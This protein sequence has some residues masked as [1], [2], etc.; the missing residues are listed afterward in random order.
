[1]LAARAH[2]GNFVELKNTYMGESAK[3]GH[4][5]YLG[6]SE[7]G[8]RTNIGAGTITC[9]YDGANKSKTIMGEDVFIGSNS[10]LVA[11]L[12]L[13]D[14]STTGAGS[15]ITADIPAQALAIARGRQRN[16][17]NWPRPKKR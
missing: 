13:G 8:A 17:E 12:H 4:L 5:T 16:L 15:T 2:V 7:I 9:N 10:S 14:G 11:P 6:D 3:A 1:M